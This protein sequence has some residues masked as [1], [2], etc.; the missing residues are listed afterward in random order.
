MKHAVGTKKNKNKK[1]WRWNTSDACDLG[2]CKS[3]TWMTW[4]IDKRSISSKRKRSTGAGLDLR[5]G[6]FCRLPKRFELA[7]GTRVAEGVSRSA[8]RHGDKERND[9]S[10][11]TRLCC[12]PET[13]RAGGCNC[14]VDRSG[15]RS[16]RERRKTLLSDQSEVRTKQVA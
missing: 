13:K 4:D 16:S 2:P 5:Q 12:A 9:H 14:I 6:S 1:T 11:E 8:A 3:R 15:Q 10:L 7:N